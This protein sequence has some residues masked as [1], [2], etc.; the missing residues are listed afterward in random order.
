MLKTLIGREL[1]D[2][3]MTFRFAAAVFITL[4]LVVAA[5]AVLIQDYERRLESYNTSIETHRQG[6]HKWKT[7]SPGMGRLY[8][9]RP[10]NPLSLFNVGLDKRLGNKIQVSHWFVPALWDAEMD[11]S[12]NSFLN[13]FSSIDIVFIFEVVLS[14]LAL[15]FAYDAL[16][17]ERERSTLRLVLTHPIR[18]GHILLAKYISAMLCLLVPLLMSLL[19]AVILLTTSTSISLSTADF[20]RMGGIVLSSLMYLSVFYL[21]GLLISSVTR[22]TSTALMLSMFVWGF[23]VL[24]YP[25][26][27][28]ATNVPQDTSGARA[29]SAFN[30]IKQIYEEFDRER[31]NFLANDPVP[32][33]DPI[34][35]MDGPSGW[36]GGD[37]FMENQLTLLYY[38]WS[39]ISY[40]DF[41]DRYLPKVQYAQNYH[42]FLGPRMVDTA[43]R[44]WLIRKQVL[45]EIFV[46]PA[47]VDRILLKLSP[48]GMYDATTQAWAGTDLR[49]IQDFFHAVREYRQAVV[50]Y[51]YDRKAFGSRQWLA[52]D[53]GK[54]DWDTLPQFSFQ[55]SDIGINAKRAFPDLFLLLTI[56]IVLFV[57]IF[58]IF[59][60]SE[61]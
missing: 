27:I 25:N 6:L 55:R 33:D 42:G 9:D 45:Q 29:A 17:G 31:K 34:F 44:A 40:N 19:L 52:V 48:V 24:V 4:L 32:G 54:V 8:I 37:G 13:I 41:Y 46:T 14:L 28:L 60:K 56:N 38:Y 57:M 5:T 53:K 49:G 22:R 11:S 15:I 58:L 35:D 12:D 18:R 61:V 1:L 26:M 50:A 3:L 51:L 2:N 39:V 10:P 7:Y 47:F 36:S 16:A 20:L 59:I 30:Q 43:N 21:I 23:L